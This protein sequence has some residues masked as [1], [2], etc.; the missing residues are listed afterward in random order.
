MRKLEPAGFRDPNRKWTATETI[1]KGMIPLWIGQ[2][3]GEGYL[4]SEKG[5]V[6]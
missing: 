2:S 6:G 3:V 5:T 4:G 1:G